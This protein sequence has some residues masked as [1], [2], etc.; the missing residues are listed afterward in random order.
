MQVSLYGTDQPSSGCYLIHDGFHEDEMTKALNRQ[1]IGVAKSIEDSIALAM[2][3]ADNTSHKSE[4]FSIMVAVS[5]AEYLTLSIVQCDDGVYSVLA[6]ELISFGDNEAKEILSHYIKKEL[7]KKGFTQSEIPFKKNWALGVSFS[8]SGKG[9]LEVGSYKIGELCSELID[10]LESGKTL[11]K[12]FKKS[13]LKPKSIDNLVIAGEFG[14]LQC[15]ISYLEDAI[16]SDEKLFREFDCTNLLSEAGEV[17]LKKYNLKKES[18]KFVDVGEVGKI[19]KNVSLKISNDTLVVLIPAGTSLPASFEQ[20][21]NFETNEVRDHVKITILEGDSNLPNENFQIT[22]FY[23]NTPKSSVV[24]SK[25]D[26]LIK[27][28]VTKGYHM[29]IEAKAVAGPE[30]QAKKAYSS[31][32]LLVPPSIKQPGESKVIKEELENHNFFTK[33]PE[34]QK[35]LKKIAQEAT[36]MILSFGLEVSMIDQKK[37]ETFEELK[38]RIDDMFITIKRRIDKL[39]ADNAS[40][41]SKD[42]VFWVEKQRSKLNTLIDEFDSLI[43]KKTH[44][45]PFNFGQFDAFGNFNPVDFDFKAAF[46]GGFNKLHKPLS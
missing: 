16:Q 46:G 25:V 1:G 9:K 26:I 15:L 31:G 43:D 6:R 10:K 14:N 23:V 19:Y 34:R 41:F 37:A 24:E 29:N 42:S 32:S 20:K 28:T 8:E 38:E 17:V 35:M 30:D 12:L 45:D 13:L 33:D 36:T 3:V 11:E 5:S 18:Q 44:P 40:S 4:E 21:I 7:L 22:M 27:V 39:E 2:L